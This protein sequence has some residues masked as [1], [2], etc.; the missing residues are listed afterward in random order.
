MASHNTPQPRRT[1]DLAGLG[2][3]AGSYALPTRG[4][5]EHLG[6][7]TWSRF[8]QHFANELPL[9]RLTAAETSFLRE[10]F[11][12]QAEERRSQALEYFYRQVPRRYEAVR[13]DERASP[14]VASVAASPRSAQSLLLLGSTGTGKTHLAFAALHELAYNGVHMPW[15]AYPAPDLFAQLRP[16]AGQDSEAAFLDMANCPLL[17]LDD[18]GT[19][20]L[21]EWT[22]EVTYRLINHRYDHCLP[23]IFASNLSPKELSEVLGARVASRLTQMCDRI[24][25]TGPD[26]RKEARA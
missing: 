12:S 19:A 14:W 3:P 4:D 18:L 9:A 6:E 16:R 22:E 21:S 15:R 5:A 11:M 13:P 8:T 1:V 24:V 25:L 20:K 7:D 10:H 17:F 23:S 2:V 26:R